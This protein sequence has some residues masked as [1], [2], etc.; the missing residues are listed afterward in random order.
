MKNRFLWLGHIL[1]I[2]GIFIF[3]FASFFR[4]WACII[5]KWIVHV[6]L[7]FWPMLL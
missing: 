5:R 4:F 2:F 3:R 6:C 7:L 1:F